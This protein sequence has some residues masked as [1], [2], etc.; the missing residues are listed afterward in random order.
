MFNYIEKKLL[1]TGT[2]NLIFGLV[3]CLFT[4]KYMKIGIEKDQNG[5]PITFVPHRNISLAVNIVAVIVIVVSILS[6][7]IAISLKIDK[8]GLFSWMKKAGKAIRVFAWVAL[9]GGIALDFMYIFCSFFAFTSENVIVNNISYSII[10]IIP[11]TVMVISF[12]F[13]LYGLGNAADGGD[14]TYVTN[15]KLHDMNPLYSDDDTRKV[16]PNCGTRTD[17]HSCPNCGSNV[18]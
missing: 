16:C 4:E 11:V 18:I 10:M 17:R 13:F 5:I 12:A 9:I 3:F 15:T 6:L 8:R 7:V 14:A 2:L 1:L